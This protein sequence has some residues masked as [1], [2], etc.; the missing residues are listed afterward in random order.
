MNRTNHSGIFV[1]HCKQDDIN[2]ECSCII[3]KH[4]LVSRQKKQIIVLKYQ[5]K[6]EKQISAS[7][8]SNR[9]KIQK[10]IIKERQSISQVSSLL[11]TANQKAGLHKKIKQIEIETQKQSPN[12]IIQILENKQIYVHMNNSSQPTLNIRQTLKNIDSEYTDIAVYNSQGEK[13][14]INY[15]K[16][17]TFYKKMNQQRFFSQSIAE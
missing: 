3:S 15:P 7:E 1:C 4:Q 16:N 2:K 5:N 9:K 12:S 13:S 14:S 11:Q 6:N 10:Q 17:S 8:L